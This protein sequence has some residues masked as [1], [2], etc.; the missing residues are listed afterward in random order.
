MQ[1]CVADSIQPFQDELHLS[2]LRD[3]FKADAHQQIT[4]FVIVIERWMMPGLF[5]YYLVKHE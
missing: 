5:V 4:A 1:V 2:Q 3:S